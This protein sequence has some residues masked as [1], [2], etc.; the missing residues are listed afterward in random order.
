MFHNCWLSRFVRSVDSDGPYRYIFDNDNIIDQKEHILEFFLKKMYTKYS[1]YHIIYFLDWF[2]EL[3][4]FSFLF[5]LWP[6]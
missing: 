3:I 5:F 4:Y 1:W 6:W 2:L